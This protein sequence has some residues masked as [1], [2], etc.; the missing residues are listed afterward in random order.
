MGT[1]MRKK[2][3][4][5]S[6]QNG[7][8][9]V[10]SVLFLAGGGIGC[11]FA[12]VSGKEGAQELGEYLTGYL[13]L[14]REDELPR[15]LWPLLWGQMKY[16]IAAFILSLTAL[17]VAGLPL[18]F[19]FRGFSFTFP[20]ACFCRVFGWRGMFPALALFVLPALLW[21]SSLFL[22]GPP[23]LRSAQQLLRR[24]LGEGGGTPP[25]NAPFWCQAGVCA[26]LGLAAGLLEYWGVPTLLQGVVWLVL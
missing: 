21:I 26:I 22:I 4:L 20:V 10:L 16:L 25:L 11:L 23:G 3:D 18:L 8:L 13:A 17:G 5:L 2:W 15:Q 14:A 12:A 24:A 9:A 19:A 1:R 6:E 7:A